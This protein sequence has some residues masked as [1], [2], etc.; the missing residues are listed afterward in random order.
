MVTEPGWEL[1]RLLD[2]CCPRGTPAGP[3]GS[4]HLEEIRRH[5]LLHQMALHVLDGT[6]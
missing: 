5:L 4:T 3:G 6:C 2:P 1:T